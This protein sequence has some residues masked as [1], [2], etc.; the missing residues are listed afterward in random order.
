MSLFKTTT[1]QITG[2]VALIFGMGAVKYWCGGSKKSDIIAW[3]LLLLS[4]GLVVFFLLYGGTKNAETALKFKIY[5]MILS[6]FLVILSITSVMLKRKSVKQDN[7]SKQKQKIHA[8]KIELAN[9][10][11]KLSILKRS[12]EWAF[13]GL[14][15]STK[16]SADVEEKYLIPYNEKFC[17]FYI[18]CKMI[19]LAILNVA[20][21][22]FLYQSFDGPI[23][24]SPGFN[25]LFMYCVLVTLFLLVFVIDQFMV[26]CSESEYKTIKKENR[27]R[28]NA[29]SVELAIKRHNYDKLSKELDEYNNMCANDP[30]GFDQ[31]MR[32]QVK[33]LKVLSRI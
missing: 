11:I 33:V 12:V 9:L 18:C 3:I 24:Q 14:Y 16:V 26:Y 31:L 15:Y 13:N 23:N 17:D 25:D 32:Q 19:K 1:G 5:G 27:S 29:L 7:V 6:S 21:L 30:I 8:L 4:I 22:V 28:I 10:K 20:L 2:I